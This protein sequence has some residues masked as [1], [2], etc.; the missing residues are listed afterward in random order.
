MHNRSQGTAEGGRAMSTGRKVTGNVRIVLSRVAKFLSGIAKFLGLLALSALVALVGSL[1]P[2]C[3]GTV[4]LPRTHANVVACRYAE[5]TGPDQVAD[6]IS[7]GKIARPSSALYK[8]LQDI[9]LMIALDDDTDNIIAAEAKVDAECSA[10]L[11]H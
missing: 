10:M 4:T 3:G 7:T 6:A 2:S 11:G 9:V 1:I 8:Q 5:A